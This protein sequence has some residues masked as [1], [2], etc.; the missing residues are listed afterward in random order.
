MRVLVTGARGMLGSAVVRQWA[1]RR[2][3]DTVVA[4]GRDDLDLTDAHATAT[5]VREIAPELVIHAAA[6]VGGIE[7]KRAQPDRFASENLAIDAAVLDAAMRA[8]VPSLVYI[9][10]AMVYPALAEN[11]IPE[12]AIMGGPLEAG[13]EPYALSKVVGTRRCAYISAQ[14]GL[15]FRALALS[16]LFGPGDRFS[17]DRSH[18][19]ASA[20]RKVVD[21]QLDGGDEVEIWGDGTARREFTFAPDIAAWLADSAEQ[22]AQWPVLMNIGTGTDHSVAEIYQTV[23]DIVGYTGSMAFD[24][25]RPSGV[26]QRLLDSRAAADH[27]WAPRT[28]WRDGVAAVIED[29]RRS[30]ASAGSKGTP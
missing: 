17:P 9:S 11:P 20:V 3:D 15:A 1:D 6:F 12:S 22:V 25:S 23:A 27:G 5:A 28:P 4:L 13:S 8:A 18:L 21:A 2:P 7:A 29:Y 10:S 19:L 24:P 26:P 14:E 16:N 30:R